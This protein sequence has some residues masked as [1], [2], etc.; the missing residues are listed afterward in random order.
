MNMIKKYFKADDY[1]VLLMQSGT[2]MS[3]VF[4][5]LVEPENPILFYSA[6]LF[7][8]KFYEEMKRYHKKTS[9][10]TDLNSLMNLIENQSGE[11]RKII[12]FNKVEDGLLVP[13]IVLP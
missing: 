7:S 4:F 8:K 12:H 6:G 2:A 3:S 11:M 10:V 1:E 13:D 9:I 5:N